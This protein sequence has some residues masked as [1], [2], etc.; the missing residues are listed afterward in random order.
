[1]IS[2]LDKVL[3]MSFIILLDI[4]SASSKTH[5]VV[6]LAYPACS[7]WSCRRMRK[8][9]GLRLCTDTPDLHGDVTPHSSSLCGKLS[10][11]VCSPCSPPFLRVGMER[12]VF[13]FPLLPNRSIQT[14]LVK[15]EK[16]ISEHRQ[17][18]EVWALPVRGDMFVYGSAEQG[19]AHAH[20]CAAFPS[21]YL[22]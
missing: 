18:S 9:S 5:S 8:P 22:K 21:C 14:Q 12:R 6:S 10:L 20:W 4:D 13:L 2:S 17:F 19:F 11:S 1:M 7:Y 16:L 15:P 3:R